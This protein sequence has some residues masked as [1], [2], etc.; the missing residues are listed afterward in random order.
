MQN[1]SNLTDI[2][3]KGKLFVD[4]QLKEHND[5]IYVFTLNNHTIN[6]LNYVEIFD[7]FDNINLKCFIQQGAVEI[8]RFSINEFEVLPMYQHLASPPTAWITT[9]WEFS[10]R[11]PFY[12]W[13]HHTTGQGR[14]F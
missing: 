6:T 14:I 7:L 9:N 5:A 3:T 13:K 10:I 4:I 1:F 8:E 2:N 12:M 11:E